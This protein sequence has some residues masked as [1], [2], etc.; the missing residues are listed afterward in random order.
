VRFE[1][2]A[3]TVLKDLLLVSMIDVDGN[4]TI[5]HVQ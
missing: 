4:G 1:A 2:S 3:G 5:D